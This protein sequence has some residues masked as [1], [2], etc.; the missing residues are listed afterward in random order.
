MIPTMARRCHGY[1][2]YTHYLDGLWA[3]VTKYDFDRIVE[4][5]NPNTIEVTKEGT[6]TK[7][8]FNYFLRLK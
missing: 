2:I 7:G 5:A 1:F 3:K 6:E 8:K 4:H